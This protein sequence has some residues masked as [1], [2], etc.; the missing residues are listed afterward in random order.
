MKAINIVLVSNTVLGLECGSVSKLT[1]ID[2]TLKK[3]A[4]EVPKTTNTSI[5]G[6]LCLRDLY[7]EM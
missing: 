6:L 2:A 4:D 7:A 3:N 5:V 1:S